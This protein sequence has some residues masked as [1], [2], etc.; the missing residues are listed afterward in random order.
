M[1]IDQ[2][3]RNDDVSGTTSDRLT[4][5]VAQIRAYFLMIAEISMT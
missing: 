4:Q 2:S 1:N 3:R 5:A